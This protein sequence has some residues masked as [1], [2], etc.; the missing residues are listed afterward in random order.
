[1]I[2]AARRA[3]IRHQYR[4]LR[5]SA[6][7]PSQREVEALAGI[8][9]GRYWRIENGYDFPTDTERAELARVLNVQASE[10]PA[11]REEAKAS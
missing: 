1:M 3:A 11:E 9:V 8:Y 10:L 5:L 7:N 6:G 4:M 2:S